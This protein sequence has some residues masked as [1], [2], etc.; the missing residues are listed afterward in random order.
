MVH[1]AVEL[2]NPDFQLV[3]ALDSRSILLHR[4]VAYHEVPC[5]LRR[6]RSHLL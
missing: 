6:N 3:S 5:S 1:A 2:K 4:V